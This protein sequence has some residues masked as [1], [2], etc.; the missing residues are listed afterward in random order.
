MAGLVKSVELRIL[1]TDADAQAKLDAIAERAEELKADNPD[2]A[3]RID[4]AAASEKLKVLKDELNQAAG[5]A[6]DASAALKEYQDAAARAASASDD[7]AKMQ[8][9]DSGSADDMAAA[10]DRVTKAT[11]ESLDAQMRLV[12]A[13]QKAA[14][15]GKENADSQEESAG[16]TDLAA[17]GAG[18]AGHRL[19]ELALGA[20]VAAAGSVYMAMK[21]QEASTQLVTGA[22]QSEAGLAKVKSG[23]LAVST[24][25]A[26]SS[27]DIQAGMYMIESAGFHGADGLKVLAAAAEGA[28]VGNAQ[29]GDVANVVT[30]ALNAY[31]LPASQAVAITNQLVA[32][33][34]SGKMHMEDLA[35]SISNVLPIAASAHISFAQV[36]GAL[37]TMTAQGMTARRASMNLANMIRSLI[38]PSATASG[39]MKALG[40]NANDISRNI[41]KEGLT[42]TLNILT[43]AILKSSKGGE[44]LA[45][46]FNGMDPATKGLARGILAGKV[47]TEDLTTAEKGM[48]VQQ[49]AL[50]GSFAK[51][52]GSATGLKTTYDGAMKTMTGGATGLN[53]ALLLGGKHMSTFEANTKAVGAAAAKSGKDVTGWGDVTADASFKLDQAKTAGENLAI[54]VGSA[55]LPAVTD[56]LKPL[57]SAAEWLA[58]NKVAAEVLAGVV[59]GVLATYVGVKAVKAFNSVKSAVSDVTTAAQWLGQK[60]GILSGEQDAETASTDAAAASSAELTGAMDEQVAATDEVTAAQTEAD[61][62]MDA[63]PIGLIVVALAALVV[64][65]VEV[66]R[67]WQDF[68]QWGADALHFVEHAA[69]DVWHWIKSNW[70]L[71]LG[72]LTGPIGLAAGEIITH[73][74]DITKFFTEMW[75]DVVHIAKDL[76]KDVVSIFDGMWHDVEDGAKTLWRWLTDFIG[77]E[78]SGIKNILGWFGHLGAL[79]RGWWD[80]AVNAVHNVIYGD[81]LPFIRRLPHDVLHALGDMGSLLYN[82]GR[83][84]LHGLVHGI[85][86]MV[87]G[88]IHTVENVGSSILSSIEG[89]LGIGS[90]STEMRYR[91]QMAGLGLALGLDDSRSL[92]QAAS[93]RLAGVVDSGFGSPSTGGYGAAGGAAG[94]TVNVVLS[95]ESGGGGDQGFMTWLENSIRARGGSPG[96]TYRKVVF[97]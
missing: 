51:T 10:Q 32:T 24:Q 8:A 80:D 93:R 33:V 26:T 28:K 62:A 61:A 37:A 47:S 39:E 5:S 35:T 30:S 88:V 40:L 7:L 83:D 50:I 11:L 54:S 89:A 63:N 16:K 59:G 94:Q 34:A 58:E 29:L 66:V 95:W 25:T 6:D 41:G 82:A 14:L 42:G 67:H 86:S 1:A 48:S 74:K 12:G 18:E 31:H 15:A 60:L 19:N 38:S 9:S 3:V 20:G 52:A 43:E 77:T 13:E 21:W 56:I 75:H 27:S 22:G 17:A 92:V 65:I 84:L 44:A 23:M 57:A 85:E 64:G 71:L 81:L 36:G 73:W 70:P 4:T 69:E 55:L 53:V 76:W 68:K 79:F 87:G 46:S 45:A 49:A 2:L 78:I 97:Q 91:G 96:I 72:V 90:P